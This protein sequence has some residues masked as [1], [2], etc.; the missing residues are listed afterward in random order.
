M[1]VNAIDYA[2]RAIAFLRSLAKKRALN[3]SYEGVFK[4]Y[5]HPIINIGTI[6]GGS[7]VN[8]I[9]EHC[10]LEV[11]Y[12]FMPN[13][14]P[15]GLLD[16]VDAYIRNEL[17]PA[18][19]KENAAADAQLLATARPVGMDTPSDTE[20]ELAIAESTG[21]NAP[22]GV[23]FTTEGGT[24]NS[25]G[26]QSIICGPGSIDQ[27]HKANEYVCISQLAACRRMLTRLLQTPVFLTTVD[28]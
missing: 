23:E 24:F 17:R 27:A 25:V 10:Q 2:G 19:K 14:D 21:G 9:P 16:E 7:A 22:I 11:G 8:V 18:M 26:M 15:Q 20:L 4:E 13:E 12:R 6:S 28:T 1:G 5:P 3:R